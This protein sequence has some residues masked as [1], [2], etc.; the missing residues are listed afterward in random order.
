M[1]WS[2]K[3]ASWFMGTILASSLLSAQTPPSP[4]PPAKPALGSTSITAKQSATARIQ[5]VRQLQHLYAPYWI[6]EN[7]WDTEVQLRNNLPSEPLTVTPVLHAA[8]GETVTLADIIVAGN[9][10]QT[11]HISQ[12]LRQLC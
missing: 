11:I 9:D 10:T 3:S 6:A 1:N 5:D 4:K 2:S 8:S 12:T 7:G